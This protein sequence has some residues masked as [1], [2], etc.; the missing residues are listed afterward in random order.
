MAPGIVHKLHQK[1]VENMKIILNPPRF[2][3]SS[4]SSFQS[5]QKTRWLFQIDV[6]PNVTILPACT[7]WQQPC[8][9]RKVHFRSTLT[10]NGNT[11]RKRR[12]RRW[13]R[14]RRRNKNSNKN[15]VF[16]NWKKKFRETVIVVLV[17]RLLSVVHLL[18]FR[19][20]F[21]IE[22]IFLMFFFGTHWMWLSERVY[23]KIMSQTQHAHSLRPRFDSAVWQSTLQIVSFMIMNEK[24][25]THIRKSFRRQYNS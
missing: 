24:Q 22:Q 19:F 23:I 13:R 4:H 1:D 5:G 6:R 8:S 9:Q 3:F 15:V 17:I 7:L 25:T 18:V 10:W 12:R 16:G 20:F 21:F 11:H 2:F 14:R